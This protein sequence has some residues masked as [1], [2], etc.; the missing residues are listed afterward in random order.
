MTR[1][2]IDTHERRLRELLRLR[3]GDTGYQDHVERELREL[4]S[5]VGASMTVRLR[6]QGGQDI[7]STQATISELASHIHQALQTASMIDACQTAAKNHE[8]A[9]KAQESARVSQLI[10]VA[11]M[12]AAV[13][14]A[15]AAW[16][17]HC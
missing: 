13:V 9:L 15:I 5:D 8:I 12:F 3:Q 1:E 10:S 6:A 17:W 4:A 14:T 11:A 16:V 7:N 2:E